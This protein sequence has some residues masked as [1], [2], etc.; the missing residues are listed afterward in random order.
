MSKIDTL[1]TA[2]QRIIYWLI[3]RPV[4]FLVRIGVRPNHI[5]ILSLIGSI[6]ASYL[7]IIGHIGTGGSLIL[8]FSA[9]DMVDGYM[10]RAHH[11]ETRFG[12]FLDS[13]TDRY[14]E[15]VTLFA[16]HAYLFSTNGLW[17]S[18]W[19]AAALMGSLMVSYTRARAEGLGIDCKIGLMQRPER[20]VVTALGCVLVPLCSSTL[21]III[22]M[23]L[24]AI[25]SNLTAIVRIIHVKNTIKQT[26]Q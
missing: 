18:L 7:I 25:L 14:C 15:L 13:V 17:T 4:A 19:V 2:C 22:T 8:A 1:H 11:L 10:A 6:V 3:A 21:P 26:D 20:V 23:A 12:A 24:I 16:I 5:T 9:L